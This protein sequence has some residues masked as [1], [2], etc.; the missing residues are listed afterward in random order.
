MH[1]RTP[2][3]T[4]ANRIGGGIVFVL[5]AM[6]AVPAGI[7]LRLVLDPG[8]LQVTSPNTTPCGYTWSLLLFAVPI[9]VI[10]FW[11]LPR[12][13]VKIAKAAFW[14]AILILFPLGFALDFFLVHRFFTFDNAGATLGIRTWAMGAP[15]PVEEYIFYFTGFTA[16]L[17]IYKGFPGYF[18][19][20]AAGGLIPSAGFFPRQVLDQL[21][22]VQSD[23]T[24]RR[25]DKPALGSDA[26]FA[27]QLVE[28]PPPANAG[29]IC[30]GVVKAPDRS[31]VSLG[32][33]E[34]R[35]GDRL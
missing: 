35:Y 25:A 21:A 33:D 7:T 3:A 27:I 24:I 17:L 29:T 8:T 28:L 23:A 12:E 4:P 9:G 18:T 15:V 32:C 31:G 13:R 6:I 20:L 5:L 14:R 34:L 19:V 11:F 1:R 2:A 30:E 16:I 22:R 10:A 26:G